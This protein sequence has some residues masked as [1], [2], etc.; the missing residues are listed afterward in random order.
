M[1]LGGLLIG[2]GKV[3]GG[4]VL[5]NLVKKGNFWV[6]LGFL[7]RIKGRKTIGQN[8]GPLQII[9]AGFLPLLWACWPS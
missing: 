8:L 5:D 4:K 1:A 6:K 9:L 7:I 3:I 2:K